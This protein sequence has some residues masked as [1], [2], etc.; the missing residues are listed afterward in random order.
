MATQ[1]SSISTSDHLRAVGIRRWFW[2]G[3]SLRSRLMMLGA[4]TILPLCLFTV[5]AFIVT[6][7]QQKHQI[8][9]ATLGMTRA[10]A[11]AIDARMQYTIAALEAFSL[12][13]YLADTHAERL[14]AIHAAARSIRASRPEWRGV[15]LANPDGS[16]VFGSESPLGSGLR[17]TAD[18]ASLA[19]VVRTKA[20]VIGPMTAGPR[21]NIG[22][23]VRVPVMVGEELKYVLTAIV[24]TDSILDVIQ[25]QKV[26][27]DWIVSVFDSNVKRVARSKEHDR[28]FGTAPSPSLQQ[29]YAALGDKKEVAGVTTTME[30]D[31]VYTAVSRIGGTRWTIAIGASSAIVHAALWRTAWLYSV[32]LF[33]SLTVGASAFWFVSR[34]IT[35]RAQALRASAVALGMGKPLPHPTTGLPDF[36]EVS[37]ALWEAGQMRARA[38]SEREVSL[39]AETQARAAA[40]SAQARVQLLLTAT[41]SLSQSLDETRTLSALAA[42]VV[43]GMADVFRIDL[44]NADGALE[45]RLTFHRDP[46]R[47]EAIDDAA[48]SGIVAP[49]AP[50]SLP[51]VIASGREYVH[52]LDPGSAADIEDPLLRKF[53]EATG[54]TAI[55]L[56]PLVARD[57]A[58]GVMAAVQTMP[59]RRFE[60]YDAAL[61]VELGRRAALVLDHVR[62]Y[63]DC[64]NALEKAQAASRAKDEFLA[65]LGHELRNPLAPILNAVEIVKRRDGDAFGKEL[66]IIERQAKH[67]A[68]LVDDLLD[69]SRIVAGKTQLRQEEVDLLAVIWRAIEI[70]QPLFKNRPPPVVRNEGAS[71]HVHGDFLRLAQVVGNLL[72]NAT[73][74]SEPDDP[75]VIELKHVDDRAVITVE[76]R[77]IGIPADLL[78]H[79][80]DRFVQGQQNL[81]RSKSGLGLGLSI[82][83]SIVELHGGIIEVGSG[84][85]GQGTRVTVSLPLLLQGKPL[86]AE[87]TS[88]PNERKLFRVL[89]IDDN[90]DAAHTLAS[91]LT[92]M[93][94]QV[95]TALSAEE[96][97]SAIHSFSPHV[98]IVDVGLPRMDG[99]QLAGRLR[100]DKATRSIYLIALTGYGQHSDRDKAI[101]AGFNEHMTKPAGIETLEAALEG[102]GQTGDG[103]GQGSTLRGR[104]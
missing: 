2:E 46:T 67:L 60:P 83:R 20:P 88:P 44:L 9:Q 70:A 17:Q 35:V 71:P 51:W 15:V 45:R 53:A 42:A 30:G 64:T 61:V 66:Q 69:V 1:E 99:Y 8:E 52:N 28:Y 54:A 102:L 49:P 68:H 89:V 96:C 62:L 19:E 80:F 3:R 7:H 73:K 18:L 65:M 81:Q 56:V 31:E 39:R 91:L 95:L 47:V 78:P 93:G 90:A 104:A 72:S 22:Y 12:A 84:S 55:C 98:C 58:I 100:A 59:E 86:S 79:V 48:H 32:G 92:L 29:M 57:R 75:V 26:P 10:L 24:D 27:G 13:Q 82:A 94:H 5:A 87:T 34:S 101:R 41:S 97:L 16:V 14:P 103:S 6:L 38:E 76:D 77:G 50:G 37:S 85:A 23:T 11:A 43:P 33:L 74:F 63:A 21:G 4:A 36:D 40:E 25:R